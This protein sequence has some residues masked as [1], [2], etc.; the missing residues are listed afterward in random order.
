M[1]RSL[2]SA[3]SGSVTRFL[4]GSFRGVV[5][6][7]IDDPGDGIAVSRDGSTLF[8]AESED[9]T[10]YELS[11]VD[12]SRLRVV[13]GCGV[14]QVCVAPDGFV[15]IADSTRH[16]V[17]VLTPDLS[18][19]SVIGKRHL[20]FAVGVCASNDVVVVADL[21]SRRCVKV[22][23]RSDGSLLSRFGPPGSGDGELME[24]RRLCLV[25]GGSRIAVADCENHR[26][27]VF[28]VGGEF[29][30]HVGVGLLFFPHGIACSAFDELVVSGDGGFRIFSDV[31]DVLM[32]FSGDHALTDIALHDSTLFTVDIDDEVC[33][34]FE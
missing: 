8:M 25:R 28:S 17:H 9:D 4:G 20:Q 29:I 23:R 33:V 31:G 12:G 34:V 2:G 30:H 22:F 10:V 26:V 15:F 21:A 27:S 19:H 24:P 6:R 14:G 7:V 18:P 1:P 16:C 32:S 13:R 5:S 3:L 11:V